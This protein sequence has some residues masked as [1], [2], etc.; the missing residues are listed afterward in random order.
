MPA[1]ASSIP[2][3]AFYHIVTKHQSVEELLNRLYEH[4]TEIT[5]QHFMA[6]NNHLVKQVR[7]GQMVI[8]TPPS[9]Q[10]CT[11]IETALS[12]VARRIDQQL[13]LQ[14]EAEAKVVAQHY[15]LL[16]N[17]ANYS[18]M[19]YGL[20][21]NYF[22]E[23]K[24]QVEHILTEIEKLYVKNYNRYGRLNTDEFFRH[25]KLLFKR[26]DN[27]LKSMIG[28]GR[29]GIGIKRHKI[30]R[31]LG[32]STKSLVHQLKD[33]PVP[34]TEIPGF[35]KNHA[36]V[37]QYGKV[38]KGAGYVGLALDGVQSVAKVRNACLTG[39]E[40]DC[41]KSKFSE[42][43]RFAG[44]VIGGAGGGFAGS[45]TVCNMLFGFP[46]GGT[47][48]LWCGIVAGGAGGLLGGMVGSN[49]AQSR[50]EI[51]YENIYQ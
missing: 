7:P 14:A 5:K 27:I 24:S 15:D 6:I 29:A 46:S 19:G 2:G 22:K 32:L 11:E 50:G 44:S 21:I 23:H 39:T 33:H 43:G 20:A 10:Q 13:T 31:S 51:L 26:L 4:P 3:E 16:A 38:L 47:S 45:Y 49:Y 40:Q 35:T 48:L 12:E 28:R 37:V 30:K 36:R 9:A 34:I 17:V 8:I 25:R 18:G 41:T 1:I 42:G